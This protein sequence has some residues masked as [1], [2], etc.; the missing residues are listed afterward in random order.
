MTTTSGC[1]SSLSLH[2]SNY[3]GHIFAYGPSRLCSDN[4]NREN[5]GAAFVAAS[6]RL[7]LDFYG[8]PHDSP[9]R[10]RAQEGS[11]IWGSYIL[12][13]HSSRR[14]H[15]ILLDIRSWM[16]P[17]AGSGSEAQV[18]AWSKSLVGALPAVVPSFV[19]AGCVGA[20]AVGLVR[21]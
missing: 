19:S 18:G 7:A 1:E 17:N 12:G 11:G 6:A 13:G 8:E 20:C 21:V 5:P 3:N 15:V 16:D 2:F 10:L 4:A 14:V 9:R